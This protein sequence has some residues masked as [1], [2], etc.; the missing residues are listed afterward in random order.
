M[1][2]AK[3]LIAL[4]LTLVMVFALSACGGKE[5]EKAPATSGAQTEQAG[6]EEKDDL[7]WPTRNI[8]II[9]P[10]NPGGA[11]DITSRAL[12]PHIADYLGVEVTVVNM[13]GGNTVIATQ[14]VKDTEAD[15]YTM[16]CTGTE[17]TCIYAMGQ[18]ELSYRDFDVIGMA[19]AVPNAIVV[20]A[21]SPYNTPEKLIEAMKTEKLTIGVCGGGDAWAIS[22]G[23]W[24]NSA[25]L[26]T[27]EYIAQGSGY[28]SAVAAMKGELDAGACGLPEIADLLRGGE[29]ICLWA[30]IPEDIEIEGVGTI[31]SVANYFPDLADMLPFG[32]FCGYSFDNEV[33]D[34]ITAKMREAFD[35]AYNQED[36]QA[37][38]KERN[39]VGVGAIGDDAAEWING[40][41]KAN[42]WLLQEL[43][44]AACHPDDAPWGPIE[45]Y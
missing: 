36:V 1:K 5:E 44:F 32:G 13:A 33:D 2:N 6:A 3:K 41:E 24:V 11:T 39:F 16:A 23:L 25:G 18:S 4:L 9:V 15:G 29:L 37:F 12:A 40:R 19:V 45:H 21:D 27:P 17:I 30:M 10:Y 42:A 34:A 14:Y 31:K 22:T 35:Y 28:N 43:G 26:V 20:K 7:D 8:Q 38:I